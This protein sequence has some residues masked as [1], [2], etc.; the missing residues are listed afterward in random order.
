MGAATGA[1]G[2]VEGPWPHLLVALTFITGMIDAVSFLELG[3]VF[4][5]AMTGNVLILGLGLAGYGEML[6]PGL[7]LISFAAGA[8]CGGRLLRARFE[9]RRHRLLPAGTAVQTVLIAMAAVLSSRHGFSES[10]VRW[11]NIALLAFALGWEY[12]IVRVLK[13]PHLNTTVVTTTLTSLVAEPAAPPAQRHRLLSIAALLSGALTAGA[14]RPVL[15]PAGLL[16]L[17]VLILLGCTVVG[18]LAAE[19]IEARHRR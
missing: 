5:A 9:Q 14:L 3:R 2:R 10:W 1:S 12:A 8:A 11:P 7:A 17:A 6:P 16:W 13:V 18:H 4:V 19:R 15:S